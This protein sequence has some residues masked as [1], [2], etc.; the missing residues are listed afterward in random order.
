MC[1]EENLLTVLSEAFCGITVDTV[2]TPILNHTLCDSGLLSSLDPWSGESFSPVLDSKLGLPTVRIGLGPRLTA[3]QERPQHISHGANTPHPLL[4]HE[5]H[6]TL[7]LLGHRH[8]ERHTAVLNFA[9]PDSEDRD[10]VGSSAL[11]PRP[12]LCVCELKCPVCREL[13][14]GSA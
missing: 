2:I 7:G 3:L 6:A 4:P 5:N 1:S 9:L 14:V 13:H 10:V 11:L 8:W 12:A